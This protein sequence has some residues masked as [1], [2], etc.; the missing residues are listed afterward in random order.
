MFSSLGGVGKIGARQ[1]DA[2]T[3]DDEGLGSAALAALVLPLFVVILPLISI[4]SRIFLQSIFLFLWLLSVLR[5]SGVL[6]LILLSGILALILHFF[7]HMTS[8]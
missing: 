7:G 2:G 5:L 4:L 3:P 1:V 6:V 8:P